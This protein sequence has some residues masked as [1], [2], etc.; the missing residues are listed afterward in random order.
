MRGSTPVRMLGSVNSKTF[1]REWSLSYPT[2]PAE[3]SGKGG[4]TTVLLSHVSKAIHGPPGSLRGSK[5]RA[6]GGR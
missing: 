1:A 5:R 2:L 6:K 3:K 4:A